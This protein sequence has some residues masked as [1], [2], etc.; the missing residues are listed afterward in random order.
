MIEETKNRAGLPNKVIFISHFRFGN[1]CVS[2]DRVSLRYRM[3]RTN[4]N[5][6]YEGK[7]TLIFLILN[8]HSSKIGLTQVNVVSAKEVELLFNFGS[9]NV[10]KNDNGINSTSSLFHSM[11]NFKIIDAYGEFSR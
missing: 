9:K 2:N 10:T 4:R 11:F 8:L 7:K 1:E 3:K 6:F 5:P